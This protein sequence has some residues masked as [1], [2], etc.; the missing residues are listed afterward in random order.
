VKS[1]ETVQLKPYGIF[2]LAR[3]AFAGRHRIRKKEGIDPHD[4]SGELRQKSKICVKSIR[5]VT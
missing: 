3:A 2:L 1:T 4:H 5:Y